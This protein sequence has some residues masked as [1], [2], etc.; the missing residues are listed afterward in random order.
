MTINSAEVS[1]N[2]TEAV[3]F[4]LVNPRPV[5]PVD[6]QAALAEEIPGR[7]LAVEHHILFYPVQACGGLMPDH[8]YR[9]YLSKSFAKA[10]GFAGSMSSGTLCPFVR[11]ESAILR[12]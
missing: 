6:E 4:H 11:Y 10:S 1:S 9:F 8:P 2:R 12:S 7:C 5:M 3:N